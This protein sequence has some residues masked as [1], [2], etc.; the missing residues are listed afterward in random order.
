MKLDSNYEYVAHIC[1]E[2]QPLLESVVAFQ[3]YINSGCQREKIKPHSHIPICMHQVQMCVYICT[4]AIYNIAL[5]QCAANRPPPPPPRGIRYHPFAICMFKTQKGCAK[6]RVYA[7]TD[8]GA[9]YTHINFCEWCT[10]RGREIESRIL[11][12]HQSNGDEQR[13]QNICALP[14]AIN[15]SKDIGIFMMLRGLRNVIENHPSI[16]MQS[17]HNCMRGLK[18][19]QGL[20]I[21]AAAQV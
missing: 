7:Q 2:N 21:S 18:S 14:A 6:S 12:C 5:L 3:H 4:K 9:A 10:K 17:T 20:K 16:G 13:D 19:E 8:S 1:R 15:Y 11:S